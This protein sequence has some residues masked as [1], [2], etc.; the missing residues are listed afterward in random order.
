MTDDEL[1]NSGSNNG[2]RRRRSAQYADDFLIAME[3]QHPP[4]PID[5]PKRVATEPLHSAMAS[6]SD[7][8]GQ[9]PSS[10]HSSG[11][12]P[13]VRFSEDIQRSAPMSSQPSNRMSVERVR[14]SLGTGRPPLSIDTRGGE[15]IK[16]PSTIISPVS[17]ETGSP[18]QAEPSPQS[19]TSPRTRNRGYSLRRSLFNR[20]LRDGHGAAMELQPGTGDASDQPAHSPLSPVSP[21]SPISPTSSK[22]AEPTV[23]ISPVSKDRASPPS[24]KDGKKAGPEPDFSHLPH[25]E[26]WATEKASH[27]SIFRRIMASLEP[28]RKA[29]LRIQEIPPSKDGRHVDLDVTR[30]GNHS[31]ERTGKP[32]VDN[33]IRSSRYTVFN[34]LPRQLVFQFGKLANFYFLVVSILQMIP[35]LSTTGT[36]TTIIPL[37]FFICLSIAKEGWEDFKRHRLD[38]EENNRE[39]WVLLKDRKIPNID[40]ASESTLALA[41]TGTSTADSWIKIKWQ[42]IRVGDIVKLERDDPAP[43]DLALLYADGLNEVAYIET[44]ALDGETNLKNKSPCPALSKK[45]KTPDELAQCS[46]HFVVEDPNLDL[47]NF[48]GRVTINGETLP[49]TNNEI[50]YRGSVLRNTKEALGVAIYTGEETKIRM[51]ANKNPRSKAPSLQRLVNHIVIIVVIF[52]LALA[53]FNS[54]AYAIWSGKHEDDAWYL[55]GQNVPFYQILTAFIIMFNTMIPLS[56]YV[57]MEI[58]KLFQQMFLNDIDMYDEV[59]DIPLEARTSTI[60]EELGQVRYI[61]S[62]KTGTLTNNSMRFRKMSVAGTAWLHDFDLQ[63]EAALESRQKLLHKKR[64]KGKKPAR[65]SIGD[66]IRGRISTSK[67][68]RESGERP[69]G[70][71]RSSSVMSGWT[72]SARPT[73]RQHEGQTEEMLQ[74]I[75]RKPHTAF[76]QRVRF[77]LLSLAVCHTCHPEITDDG[78]IN[79]QAASPDEL[80]LVDAAKEMGYIFVDRQASTIAIKTPSP[81]L[82]GESITEVFEILEV[83]EF[84]SARKRMSVILRLPDGRICIFCKGADSILA[85]RLRRSTLAYERAQ[86]VERRASQRKSIEAQEVIRRNSSQITRKDSLPRRSLTMGRSSIGGLGRVSISSTR[87]QPIRDEVDSWLKDRETDVDAR[88]HDEDNA[89]YTPRPSAQFTA[90]HS[91]AFGESRKAQAEADADELVEESLVNDEEAVFERC[92]QHINDFATEGLR[93]LLYGYKFVE[94]HEYHHW[95]K[96]YHDATTSLVD[97]QEKVEKAAEMIE[98]D[99]ELAGATAIEDKLQKGVPETI[100]KL[101]RANIR[102]WMLTGDKRETAI[103]IG[104]SCRLI[105][106]YSTITILDSKDG[107][108]DQTIAAA[109]LDIRSGCV[110]HSVI[111]ID[112]QTLGNIENNEMIMKLFIELAVLADSVICCRA[113]PSQKASLVAHIRNKVKHTVTLAIG[114]GANDIAMI[115]EAHVG[116][117]IAGKEGLQAARSSDYSIAQFRF[118]LKLLLVHGRWNY[119]RTCK[120]TLGTFWKEMVFYLTQALFQRWGGYTGTSLY[121]AWSMSMFNTLFTSLPVIILG[122]FEKDLSASTLLAVPELYGIGQRNEGFNI[123]VYLYWMFTAASEAVII[124]FSMYT[125]YGNDI[126]TAENDLY[127]MGVL[128]FTC[129]IVIIATKLQ[130][131]EMHYRSIINAIGVIISVGG[132]WMFN[133]LLSALYSTSAEYY[134]NGALLNRFGK[135]LLWWTCILLIITSVILFEI[136][137]CT[138]KNAFLP[139][140]VDVFQEF[141]QD[142]FLKKRFEE[143][144]ANELQQGWDRGKKKSSLEVARE[145]AV[146]TARE[147]QVQALLDRPRVMWEQRKGKGKGKGKGKRKGGNSADERVRWRDGDG[148]TDDDDNDANELEIPRRGSARRTDNESRDVNRP[149]AEITELLSRGFGSV[150]RGQELR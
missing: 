50:V 3:G 150:R 94:E 121:E 129:C 118:L 131:I 24:I 119:I 52:V 38:K 22:K 34:F 56:L 16:T 44:M 116:I 9:P 61:F 128:T 147:E 137:L 69:S 62:D 48:D 144:A 87:L 88:S 45:C 117:G 60:N 20:N 76:A 93:T 32:Y 18:S 25:Y 81:A 30:K 54:A 66:A 6:S 40:E 143:A 135:E 101:R 55:E 126:L 4:D 133:L 23:T 90:R 72:S 115:Q 127:S 17:L 148:A 13:R 65:Q 138:F 28:L 142:Q 91:N 64:S 19:P 149:S 125:L 74:Y 146:Q 51:N 141:E 71:P 145:Q 124:Y 68:R 102:L 12:A 134:V 92:F 49:L 67:P 123:K 7:G 82:D 79:Y 97:R 53:V 89:Y 59:S 108:V 36:Y 100:D 112:G 8:G 47:Y 14:P 33:S 29:I 80:A 58:V 113:S 83:I 75:Q 130:L 111:V 31:D 78:D 95:K 109:E 105:K 107:H 140:D 98:Q 106:D 39:A 46:V 35:S 15:N 5:K 104:H 37:M 132:W 96:L 122:I 73:K 85:Q 21:V 42:N 26:T 77:F 136:A 57:S 27:K 120:Y 1:P 63:E 114:D 86:Q 2:V 10:R 43:A 99:F 41:G 139:S 110:A 11:P 103:N 84:S 70:L